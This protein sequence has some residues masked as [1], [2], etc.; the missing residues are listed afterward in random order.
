MSSAVRRRERTLNKMDP[1]SLA[2]AFL[3]TQ[4]TV[5]SEAEESQRLT[6]ENAQLVKDN[7]VLKTYIS[8][9]MK[10]VKG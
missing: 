2:Q 6:V 9:V 3:I 8:N 4:E 10:R 7:A 5:C 1:E